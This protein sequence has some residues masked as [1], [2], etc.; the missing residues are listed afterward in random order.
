MEDDIPEIK[1]INP[2][3]NS[4]IFQYALFRWTSKLFSIGFK[5]DLKFSDLYEVL[6]EHSSAYLGDKFS[7]IWVNQLKTT[8]SSLFRLLIKCFGRLLVIQLL[9]TLI[10]E[11]VVKVLQPIFLGK[12]VLFYVPGQKYVSTNEFYIYAVGII[13]CSLF[14]VM[15]AHPC[16]MSIV[17]SCMK[18]RIGCCSLIYRKALKLSKSSLEQSS[19]GK[20]VNLISN[21]VGR[22]DY[23]T[24]LMNYIIVAPIQTLIISVFMWYEIGISAFIGIII[25]LLMIPLEIW[26]GEKIKQEKEKAMI[27]TDERLLLMSEI[28]S[29]IKVI[30]M[31]AWE[32][33]FSK[34]LEL[35]RRKEINKIKHMSYIRGIILSFGMF[36]TRFAMFCS[37]LVYVLF[38]NIVTAEKVF[39]VTSFYN[40]IRQSLTV[41][42]PTAIAM[43]AEIRVTLN[44]LQSF[45]LS[46]EVNFSPILSD[47][48]TDNEIFEPKIPNEILNE[49]DETV[50]PFFGK[51]GEKQIKIKWNQLPNIDEDQAH[52]EKINGNIPFEITGDLLKGEEIKLLDNAIIMETVYMTW[53]TNRS[54]K[55]LS[56]ISLNIKSGSLVA[57]VGEVGSGKSSL[58]YTLLNEV[59]IFSGKFI[60]NGTMSYASQDS[61]IFDS[62]ICQ[63]I[64]FGSKMDRFRY[65]EVIRNC[66][67]ESDLNTFKD[68]D[69]TI[70][71]ER[72]TKLSGGQQSRINLARAAYRNA[73]IYLLD[74]PLAAVDN[75]VGRHIFS[76][77]IAGYLKNKT[78]VL[79]THQYQ[80]L[81]EVDHIIMLSDGFIVAEGSYNDLIENC[82]PFKNL[83]QTKTKST[84]EEDNPS[85]ETKENS[86]TESME[87]QESSIKKNEETQQSGSVSNWVYRSYIAACGPIIFFI[88]LSMLFLLTQILAS[89]TDLWITAWVNAEEINLFEN[90]PNSTQQLINDATTLNPFDMESI[91]ATDSYLDD[92]SS[93]KLPR[94]RNEYILTYSSAIIALVIVTIVRSLMYFNMSLTASM[95]LHNDMFKALIR[96]TMYVF[97]TIPSG[98]ILNRFSKDVGLIDE[99]LTRVG[100]DVLQ[101]GLQF[102]GILIVIIIVNPYFLFPTLIMIGVFIYMRS[103]YI[104]TS[105]SLKRLEGIAR[106]PIVSHLSTSLK[107]LS[108]IRAYGVQQ[109]LVEE[110]DSHQDLHSSVWFMFLGTSRAFGLWLDLMCVGFISAIV[111]SF[112]YSAKGITAGNVGLMISQ[113]IALTGMMQW[114]LRQSAELENLMT[115]VERVLEYHDVEQEPPL[116]QSEDEQL[117][118]WPYKGKIEFDGLSLRYSPK[119]KTVLKKLTFKVLPKEKLGIVGR[120]GSGKSSIINALFRM[121]FTE[122]SVKIDDIETSTIGLHVLRSKIS[123]I[124][125][126]PVLFS[127]TLRHNLDP[128]S[129]CDDETLWSALEK[130]ELK[131]FVTGLTDGLSATISEGGSNFSVGQRQLICLAR[132]I[133]CKNNILV[134]DEATANVDPRTDLLIQKTIREQFKDYTVITI[135]HRLQTIIDSDKI[136]VMEN[137]KEVEFDHPY[138]LLQNENGK[139]TSMVKRT[140]Q[141]GEDLNEIAKKSYNK[142]NQKIDE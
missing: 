63:N 79:I 81:T 34:L 74:D 16:A 89:F 142:N 111:L 38:G 139:F 124:P 137:G 14:H 65:N 11:C 27:L 83:L 113:A 20:I 127:G 128:F 46:T 114:G 5:R 2:C 28:L 103:Y 67:L 110:F 21:D 76:E 77:C 33:P 82:S 32:K 24:V 23:S 26:L 10:L 54:E 135:A 101:I 129:E 120:S 17:H 122:G 138:I 132:A 94:Q 97:H 70:A 84:E 104:N 125:Q 52:S 86:L 118:H 136:L 109:V 25:L 42:F 78:R 7:R 130:V 61:W 99:A 87:L 30:K 64:L 59:P 91:N 116:H 85:Q 36:G 117:L 22:F 57:I 98:R 115:S 18:Y 39:I 134:M 29:G 88:I 53:D 92:V 123:I 37:I 106:T 80:Y 6:H 93:D 96:A 72:G 47:L 31:Y 66:A 140:K 95:N 71:G 105:R 4:N 131:E 51:K 56:N 1:P 8:S 102:F 49:S 60:I 90:S 58:F 121:A 40:T 13:L 15:I 3:V 107:G 55:H 68:G 9:V 19:M 12:L 112:L 73:D 62:S 50:I 141:I 35:S 45:L 69:Q 44:R 41:L 133:V 48:N 100:S 75:H 119:G 108:T 126:E 43:A